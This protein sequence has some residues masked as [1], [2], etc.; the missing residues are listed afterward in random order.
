[1]EDLTGIADAAIGDTLREYAAA[2]FTGVL[3][4]EGQP[5]GTIYLQQGGISAA[6]RPPAPPASR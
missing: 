2:R 4:V 5:G 6:A 1:M 3:R